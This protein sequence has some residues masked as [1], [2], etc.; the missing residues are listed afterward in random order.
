MGKAARR[1][2]EPRAAQ[3]GHVHERIAVEA[4]QNRESSDFTIEDSDPASALG[5]LLEAAREA[6]CNA[7]PAE[8]AYEGRTYWLRMSVGVALL[9]VFDSPATARPIAKAL[10]G[11]TDRFGHAPAH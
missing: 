2:R 3:R 7:A 5:G 11:S 9:E 4:R 6:M 1:K 10:T 8:F